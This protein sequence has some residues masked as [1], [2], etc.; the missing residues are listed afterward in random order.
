[1]SLHDSQKK[2]GEEI[3]LLGRGNSTKTPDKREKGGSLRSKNWK[4]ERRVL[5]R[6]GDNRGRPCFRGKGKPSNP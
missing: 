5:L 2:G 3:L 4:E 6:K 1:M